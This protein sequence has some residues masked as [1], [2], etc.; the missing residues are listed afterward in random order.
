MDPIKVLTTS[1]SFTAAN[2]VNDSTL[3]TADLTER[4]LLTFKDSEAV[5]KG[6]IVLS[7]GTYVLVKLKTDTV[8]ANNS[9]SCS[10]IAY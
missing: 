1:V 6:S 9:I 10:G 5:T 8:E 4:T 7:E 3:F 2:T